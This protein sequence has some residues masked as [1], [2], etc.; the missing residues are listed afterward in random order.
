[1]TIKTI[2]PVDE[3]VLKEYEN[4]TETELKNKIKKSREGFSKWKTDIKNRSNFLHLLSE[5]LR[6]NKQYL[7]KVATTEMGKPM[8][9]S[10]AEVEKCAWV[11]EFYGDNGDVFL[12]PEIINTDA[13]KSFISFEPIGVIGS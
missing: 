11:M 6:K 8:K 7:A 10:L 12:N 1:M 9:E 4:I 13:R 3:E 2:N 5:Q